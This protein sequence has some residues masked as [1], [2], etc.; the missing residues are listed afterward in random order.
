ME[1]VGRE[2]N[3]RERKGENERGMRGIGE[4]RRRNRWGKERW[5]KWAKRREVTE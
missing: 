4:G 1:G 3:C 5:G 2:L